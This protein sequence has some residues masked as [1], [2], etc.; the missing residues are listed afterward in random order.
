[1]CIISTVALGF[2]AS[3]NLGKKNSLSM[4]TQIVPTEN[5]PVLKE[6]GKTHEQIVDDALYIKID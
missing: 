1:M 6:F 2:T 5:I 3:A 4:I